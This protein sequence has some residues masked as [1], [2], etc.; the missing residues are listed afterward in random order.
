MSTLGSALT[1]HGH[2]YTPLPAKADGSKAPDVTTWRNI[3]QLDTHQ[4]I[5]LFKHDPH[6]YG[7]LTGTPSRNLEMLEAEGRAVRE[8]ILQALD[9]AFADHGQE[10]LW[11]R[12]KT[13]YS[14]ATPSGGIHWYI[15]CE[16]AAR[17]NTK[18]ARRPST[19]EELADNPDQKIQVLLETRGEGGYSIVA[20][21][22]GST[23]PTG[24][25]WQ[26]LTGSPATI[27]T[28]TVEER[29]LVFAIMNT[30]D[31]MPEDVHQPTVNNSQR[32]ESSDLRPG[33]DYNQRTSWDDLLI[34]R[35]WT[36]TRTIGTTVMWTR[37]G[38]NP[39]DG[40]SATTGRNAADN[41]FVFSSS[42]EF[43]TEK[44]YSKFSAYALLEH[45][46]DYA[47]AAR[48]LRAAGYGSQQEPVEGLIL[49]TSQPPGFWD[50]RPYLAI[51][52]EYAYARMCAPTA[53]LGVVLMRVLASIPPGV[54]L[55][56]T[57][58]GHG[59]LNLFL[60]MVGPSGS[61]K[62]ASD[63]CARNAV[64]GLPT[65]HTVTL[66]SGEGIA[67]QYR[68]YEKGGIVFDRD[69][70]H[71]KIAEI[72]TIT[73]ISSRTGSTLLTQLRS[74]YSGEQL[75]F[76]YADS[77]RRIPL[78]EHEYRLVLTCGVQPEKAAPLLDDAD[79][80]TPQRFIWMPTTDPNI[81]STPP[82]KPIPYQV[83]L[84]Q[85]GHLPYDPISGK[86][87]INIPEVAEREIRE[88][89]AARSRGDGTALDG[90][91]LFT[92]EKVAVA[93]MA[94]DGRMEVSEDDWKIAGQIMQISDQTRAGVESLLAAKREQADEARARRDAKREIIT[95]DVK[96][97]DAIRK[98]AGNLSKKVKAAGRMTLGKLRETLNSRSRDDFEEALDR[99]VVAGQVRIEGREVIAEDTK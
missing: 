35:G 83:T 40:I 75:G 43:D 73:S 80:G 94:L 71:F 3:T 68:H 1:W 12:V 87:V 26:A 69:T 6:G 47:A 52:R 11:E 39:R 63:S 48:A 89:R 90:H 33:D 38:K 72:D 84:P 16:G 46:G 56:D 22:N 97:E 54:V 8:G 60:A 28:L 18:L 4:V 15:R 31:Q 49:D 7:I 98:I 99:L 25:S 30:L 41:L 81:S 32:V 21:S 17:R 59:S 24:G 36:K 19:P 57:I 42:T 67:H 70:V 53:V 85:W 5:A 92:R 62:G 76:A 86:R 23:H 82:P 61:G 79:G 88:A 45:H 96:R 44:P 50:Q 2:G 10:D 58:G 77:S 9:Q 93:L 74:A 51:I 14:E 91:S 27:P 78:P 55:P 34:P 64:R 13:G 65:I 20:P 95:D 66:G 37:P 29:D